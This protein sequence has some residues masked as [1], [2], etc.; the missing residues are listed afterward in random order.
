[1]W[2]YKD[3][4]YTSEIKAATRE[5]REVLVEGSGSDQLFAYVNYADGDETLEEVY[6]HE[7]WRLQK[8]R[9]LKKK[10]DPAGVFNFYVPIHG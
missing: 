7:P 9:S 5:I 4:A 1:M 2:G 10:Y 3:P 6:G 8:L